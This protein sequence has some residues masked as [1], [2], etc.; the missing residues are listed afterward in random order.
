[1]TLRTGKTF[2]FQAGKT[3]DTFNS[4]TVDKKDG[5]ISSS[6]SWILSG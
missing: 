6:I 1:M 5:R 2:S 3:I 4:I